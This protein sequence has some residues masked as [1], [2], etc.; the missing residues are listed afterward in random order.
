MLLHWAELLPSSS[1]TAPW[2]PGPAGCTDRTAAAEHGNTPRTEQH[3]ALVLAFISLNG[4]TSI[5]LAVSNLVWSLQLLVLHH[6]QHVISCAQ[7]SHLR[8]AVSDKRRQADE[9]QAIAVA[10]QTLRPHL[11]H[12]R[13]CFGHLLSWFNL[14]QEDRNMI[15]FSFSGQMCNLHPS[16]RHVG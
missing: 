8:V 5:K 15:F 12:R 13:I 16:Y 2:Q 11:R 3:Q 7:S 6:P 4:A 1:Q 14:L 10:K 9:P